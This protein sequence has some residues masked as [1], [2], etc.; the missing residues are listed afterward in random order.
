MSSADLVVLRYT[1][2]Y[3]I[4]TTPTDTRAVATLTGTTNP[5]D[6]DT[7]TIGARTYTFQATLTDVDGNVKIGA[8]LAASLLNLYRAVNDLGGVPGTDYAAATT[9]HSTVDAVVA[10]STFLQFRAKTGGTGG[11]ALASTEAS[12]AFSFGAA[13]FAGGAVGPVMTQLRYT[14]ESLNFSIENTKTAEIRPDRTETDTV[15]TSASGAGDLN[16]EL[17]Y[18]TFRDFLAA[19]FCSVWTPAGA[20]VEHLVNGTTLQA[21]SIQKEFQD[22]AVPQFHTF[23]GSCIEGFSIKM[24]IGKIVEGSFNVMSFGADVT[25]TPIANST[26][27]AVTQTTPMNAV[28]NVQ[29]LT[30][31]GVPYAGC[32]S[33]LGLQIKN[34]IRAIQCIGSLQARGMKLGTL[35][36]TGDMEFYFNEG[37]NYENFVEGTEFD[38]SFDL[39]DIDGNTYRFEISRA[40]FESGEVTAGGKNSD[41]MFSA[42]YRGLYHVSDN[43][44]IRI[45]ATDAP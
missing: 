41:V 31:A 22:M 33:S 28:T 36:V 32:I 24:E 11:N 27:P 38:V 40:K 18:D 10:T 15:Q 19:A 9:A 44:V 4:G 17:S 42:K 21:Y 29:N 43:R 45:I 37:S 34:N 25:T 6:G 26:F 2:E 30:I 23:K 35:E 1:P 39:I 20:G 13:T 3:V 8:T 7:V 5:A 12:T 14:G 16:F